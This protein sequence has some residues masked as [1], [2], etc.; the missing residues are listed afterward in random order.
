MKALIVGSSGL[1]GSALFRK[2]VSDG[3]SVLE[4]NSDGFDGKG[5][6]DFE[7]TGFLLKS[8]KFDCVISTAWD[9]RKLTYRDSLLNT[10]FSQATVNLA[11]HSK[12]CGVQTFVALGS[13]AEYGGNNYSCN[14]QSSALEPEDRYGLTKVM[15]YSKILNLLK[16]SS[17][18]FIWCR[19]FQPYGPH[20]D[21]SRLLPVLINKVSRGETL[22]L[23][24]PFRGADWISVADIVDGI[25]FSLE[26]QIQGAID[27][28]TSRLTSNQELLSTVVELF[29]PSL[30]IPAKLTSNEITGL[31]V[32]PSSPLFTLGW[33]PKI[34]LED[35]I[36]LL[37]KERFFN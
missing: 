14:A 13:A 36:N 11:F 29:K 4:L 19:V 23:D 6:F 3:H 32:S 1:I 28:G 24:Y 26:N 9:T 34:Q 27:L 33:K 21:P 5:F 37:I 17:T 20:Q 10:E 35:G 8:E 30:K 12:L 15:T 2:M 25:L 22:L 31:C 18:N 16:G 7:S